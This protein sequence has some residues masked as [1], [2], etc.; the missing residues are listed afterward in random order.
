MQIKL[1]Q[2]EKIKENIKEYKGKKID[3]FKEMKKLDEI[4]N[5]LKA[6]KKEA[7]DGYEFYRVYLGKVA[8]EFDDLKDETT[9][10]AYIKSSED[11]IN[12]LLKL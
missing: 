3:A 11:I 7:N 4:S 6:I 10:S 8:K 12:S 2:I 5:N 1:I 9:K